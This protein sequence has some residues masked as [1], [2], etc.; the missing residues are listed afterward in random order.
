[1]NQP[2]KRGP[3]ANAVSEEQRDYLIKVG[4]CL[5][6]WRLQRGF[7]SH[8]EFA[9][10]AGIARAQYLGYEH[11]ANMQLVTFLRLFETLQITPEQFFTS[12]DTMNKQTQ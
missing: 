1:M 3:K 4:R 10:K 11:G 7:T 8:E 9:Y 12:V 6:W 5:R 2:K